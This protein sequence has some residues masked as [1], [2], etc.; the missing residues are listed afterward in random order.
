MNAVVYIASART[1]E[2]FLQQTEELHTLLFD[3]ETFANVP[4]LI[5]CIRYP[6]IN[7]SEE[8]MVIL[9]GL[10]NVTTRRDRVPLANANVRPLEVFVVEEFNR[11]QYLEGI[12][13]L[14]YHLTNN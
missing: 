8:Q 14:S 2:Q 3:M 12:E 11:E 7:L 4:F 10:N 5:F 13:W 9:L 6:G 1:M